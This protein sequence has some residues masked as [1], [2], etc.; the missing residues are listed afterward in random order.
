MKVSAA[1]MSRLVSRKTA[2]GVIERS[3]RDVLG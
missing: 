2:I 1:V 3:S